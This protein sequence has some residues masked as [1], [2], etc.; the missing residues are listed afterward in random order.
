MTD[1]SPREIVSELDRYIVGQTDAK[2]AV[3]VALRNRWRRLQLDVPP[4]VA[5]P[6]LPEVTEISAS[7]RLATAT[8][9]AYTDEVAAA[10]T[11]AGATVREVQRMSLEEIFVANVMS[12][13]D[14]HAG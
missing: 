4:G 8:I 9:N 13:R 11:R 1:F 10:F 2:R 6:S 7:G 12:R 3:A 5:L 14:G